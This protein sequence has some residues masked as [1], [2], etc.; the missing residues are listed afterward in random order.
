MSALEVKY[1]RNSSCECYYRVDRIASEIEVIYDF[2]D[3]YR[4]VE[5]LP[6]RDRFVQVLEEALTP[7]SA[8]VYMAV[9]KHVL[10]FPRG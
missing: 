5:S 9:R 8:K 6:L 10:S 1:L 2:D 4:K 7:I 3:C